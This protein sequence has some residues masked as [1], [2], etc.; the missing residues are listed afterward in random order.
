MIVL[1]F[2]WYQLL[3]LLAYTVL[4]LLVGLVTTRATSPAV[5]AVLLAA[6]SVLIPLATELAH[7][8]QAGTAYDLGA[9]LLTALTGF[10]VAV[11]LH[12]GLWKPT[13]AAV[14]AQDVG[15]RHRQDSALD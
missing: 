8:L 4:P 15:A 1:D 9:A 12:Y 14:A 5:K 11:G 13:G 3:T 2:Q 6:L 10:L 7:A